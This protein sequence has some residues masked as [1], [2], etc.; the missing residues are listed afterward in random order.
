MAAE[1]ETKIPAAPPVMNT[2]AVPQT[3]GSSVPG[4]RFNKI[5]HKAA[6]LYGLIKHSFQ[7][8]QAIFKNFS[9]SRIN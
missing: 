6:V 4:I 5:K 7:I 9:I 2:Q 8:W 1:S 3:N